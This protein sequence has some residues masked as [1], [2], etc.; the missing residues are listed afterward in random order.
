M[1]RILSPVIVLCIMTIMATAQQK[2]K[3][4]AI[5]N[6]KV[7]WEIVENHYQGKP[8]F[9]SAFTFTNNGKSDLPAKGWSLYFNMARAIR[10]ESVGGG[11]A[12][13][14]INGDLFRLTPATG[15]CRIEAR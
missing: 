9:Q 15:L 7:E 1:L 6:I 12:I 5:Q 4:P 2:T 11:M 13:T 10:P 8:G 14:N 3:Q